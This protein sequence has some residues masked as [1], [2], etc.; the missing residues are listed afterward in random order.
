[1]YRYVRADS[2]QT[3][4][5]L[6]EPNQPNLSIDDVRK[7]EKALREAAAKY[8]RTA[9]EIDSEYGIK[10]TCSHFCSASSTISTLSIQYSPQVSRTRAASQVGG[11]GSGI[12]MTVYDDKSG[13]ISLYK[14][15][16]N[17]EQIFNS[18]VDAMQRDP[19]WFNSIVLKYSDFIGELHSLTE[20]CDDERYVLE[21][22][23]AE[24]AVIND[25]LPNIRKAEQR[26][27]TS[28]ASLNSI[29]SKAVELEIYP[30]TH[31]HCQGCQ[32]AY[33]Y[34][35]YTKYSDITY[36]Q[37][38][39]NDYNTSI[40]IEYNSD[41]TALVRTTDSHKYPPEKEYST[42]IDAIHGR[43]DFFVDFIKEHPDFVDGINELTGICNEIR[44]DLKAQIKEHKDND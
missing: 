24:T 25:M 1:M 19:K 33:M 8:V 4:E 23:A 21:S 26:L 28:A 40:M 18:I 38:I 14:N 37:A 31:Y 17:E 36:V 16:R 10:D 43:T 42:L 12:N 13:N 41:L 3:D 30:E 6:N 20:L 29:L 22:E 32:I 39:F 35:Y 2:E 5:K 27:K 9:E 34:L 7:A 11:S 15:Y 44:R